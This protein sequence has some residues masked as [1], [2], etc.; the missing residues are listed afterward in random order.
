MCVWTRVQIP[1][2][3][4]ILKSAAARR[5]LYRNSPLDSTKGKECVKEIIYPL[6]AFLMASLQLSPSDD[7]PAAGWTS[8]PVA[9]VMRRIKS[10]MSK[11]LLLL[12]SPEKSFSRLWLTHDLTRKT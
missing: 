1:S 12:I 9:K 5:L 11:S 2:F 6:P 7:W 8:N 3:A 4:P 10:S